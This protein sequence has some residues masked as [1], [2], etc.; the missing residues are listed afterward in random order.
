MILELSTKEVEKEL[1]KKLGLTP[2]LT[3]WPI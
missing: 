1:E 3:Q 2:G